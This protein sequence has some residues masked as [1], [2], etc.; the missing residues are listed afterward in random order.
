M[1][2]GAILQRL[3]N[4]PSSRNSIVTEGTDGTKGGLKR[5]QCSHAQK[6]VR[7]T[8]VDVHD[9]RHKLRHSNEV[10]RP[11]YTLSLALLT[12]A[13]RL[14]IV[15]SFARCMAESECEWK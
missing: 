15:A 9:T 10:Y 7:R 6:Y 13:I 4:T 3:V 1:I 8:Q 5:V 2:L 14:E 11:V 12:E